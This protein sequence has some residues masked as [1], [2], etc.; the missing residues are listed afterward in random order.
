MDQSPSSEHKI[1][2]VDREISR[3]VWSSQYNATGSYIL[4]KMSEVPTLS[5][6]IDLT[7]ILIHPSNFYLHFPNGPF[8]SRF[9]T[10]FLYILQPIQVTQA[11]GSLPRAPSGVFTSVGTV[12]LP[13][14]AVDEIFLSGIQVA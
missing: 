9:L 4:N 6:H 2:S 13:R 11:S 14:L 7:L 1:R 5:N 10:K 8:G 12:G 3:L